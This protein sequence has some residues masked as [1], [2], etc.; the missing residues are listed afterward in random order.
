MVF[1]SIGI[2]MDETKF[3]WALT[4]LA[5]RLVCSMSAE[6]SPFA[7]EVHRRLWKQ[8]WYLDRRAVE[9]HGRFPVRAK[10]S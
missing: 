2:F 6:L 10:R 1:L 7:K 8:L 3:A 4:A 9:D 5:R